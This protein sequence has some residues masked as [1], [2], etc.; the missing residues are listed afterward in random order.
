MKS[1]R[2]KQMLETMS[3]MKIWGVSAGLCV[4]MCKQNTDTSPKTNLKTKG[5]SVSHT[6]I[7]LANTSVSHTSVSLFQKHLFKA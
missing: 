7:S 2:N 1:P 5:V 3:V 6:S 4:C